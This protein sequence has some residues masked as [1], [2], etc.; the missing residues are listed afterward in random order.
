ML[1]ILF[2][3]FKLSNKIFFLRQDLWRRTP[4]QQT[5]SGSSQAEVPWRAFL[6]ESPGAGVPKRRSQAKVPKR[7]IPSE[8]SQTKYSKRRPSREHARAKTLIRIIFIHDPGIQ[9]NCIMTDKIMFRSS[10]NNGNSLTRGSRQMSPTSASDTRSPP[11]A[12]KSKASWL[13]PGSLA[14]VGWEG[15]WKYKA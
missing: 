15:G 4:K 6:S 10:L 13:R 2:L 12:P 14:A 1:C 5:P 8:R 7:R 3:L 11:L 9:S